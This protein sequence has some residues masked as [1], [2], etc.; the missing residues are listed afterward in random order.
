M[1]TLTMLLVLI[2][3][4]IPAKAYS[5]IYGKIEIGIPGNG[6]YHTNDR[7]IYNYDNTY[8][9]NITLGYKNLLFNKI[10]YRIFT[11]VFTWSNRKGINPN[12]YPF[13]DIYGLG[14]QLKYKGIYIQYN[15]F[16]AHPVMHSVN[17]Y[18]KYSPDDRSWMSKM[19]STT[20]GYEFELK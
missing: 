4:L 5:G 19:T 18:N 16:C 6:N 12:G 8:F 3:L 15:H 10:E 13:E 17:Q 20:I 1:K 11:G 7:V 14:G 2:G 9:T